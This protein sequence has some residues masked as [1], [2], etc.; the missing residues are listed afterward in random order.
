[1]LIQNPIRIA[2][3]QITKK[4][5]SNSVV[6]N[7][8]CAIAARKLP[9]SYCTVRSCWHLSQFAIRPAFNRS[10]TNLKKQRVY[11]Y[12]ESGV[13]DFLTARGGDQNREPTLLVLKRCFLRQSIRKE[14]GECEAFETVTTVLLTMFRLKI[15]NQTIAL[16][17]ITSTR[18]GCFV[19]GIGSTSV[20]C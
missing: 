7:G 17:Y 10:T 9:P 15:S 19:S 1:M 12:S 3:F 18:L 16:D 6:D 14:C 5:I 20:R 4:F 2:S 13:S 8:H 11:D